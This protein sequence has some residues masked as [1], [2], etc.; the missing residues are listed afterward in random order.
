MCLCS[1]SSEIGSTPLKGCRGNCGP[2]GKKWHPAAGIMTRVTCRLTTAK[3]TRNP[4]LDNQVWHRMGYLFLIYTA[5]DSSRPV[6]C[7]CGVR[8]ESDGI[9]GTD[10]GEVDPS[11]ALCHLA[12]RSL[13][14]PTA[15][16]SS[17][18][19][20]NDRLI[21]TTERKRC[22]HTTRST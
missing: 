18:P 11:P 9:A 5:T 4:T 16:P 1:P 3:G 21:Y 20:N 6:N 22:C 10:C 7:T 14:L 13:E 15:T 19:T 17:R 2:G 12:R 8:A